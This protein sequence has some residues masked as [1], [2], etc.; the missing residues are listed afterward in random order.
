MKPL[1]I[2]PSYMPFLRHSKLK[3]GLHHKKDVFWVFLE[4]K[5]ERKKEKKAMPKTTLFKWKQQVQRWEKPTPP[6]LTQ[7]SLW[8]H[9]LHV[10]CLYVSE[11]LGGLWSGA[12]TTTNSGQRWCH[13]HWLRLSSLTPIKQLAQSLHCRSYFEELRV[14][15]SEWHQDNRDGCIMK[16]V[17]LFK[18]KGQDFGRECYHHSW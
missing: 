12:R 1:Q 11:G 6:P 8:L 9:S 10:A 3:H 18:K 4:W 2:W 7:T 16:N 13:L 15:F 17:P 14:Q 5:I